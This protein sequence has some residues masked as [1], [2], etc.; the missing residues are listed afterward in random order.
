MFF[1]MTILMSERYQCHICKS[2]KSDSSVE[3]TKILR[4]WNLQIFWRMQI[5]KWKFL[6][7][8][9]K[10]KPSLFRFFYPLPFFG[11]VIT[12]TG[13]HTTFKIVLDKFRI[14]KKW[15]ALFF[16]NYQKNNLQAEIF[17]EVPRRFAYLLPLF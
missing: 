3:Y 10:F 9:H 13:Q 1:I 14:F 15:F 2:G 8:A 11:L 6:W 4:I 17:H 12:S 7:L 5:C 16:S